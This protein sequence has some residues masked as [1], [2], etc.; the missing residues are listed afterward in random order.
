M[1]GIAEF[2]EAIPDAPTFTQKVS[3]EDAKYFFLRKLCFV[4]LSI[5]AQVAA[6]AVPTAIVTRKEL[7]VEQQATPGMHFWMN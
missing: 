2:F 6:V 4:L 7:V 3:S 5:C 1:D